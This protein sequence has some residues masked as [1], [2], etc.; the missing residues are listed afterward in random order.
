MNA[1]HHGAFVD[2]QASYVSG[3]DSGRT[4]AWITKELLDKEIVRIY[5][6]EKRKVL[7]AAAPS[8]EFRLGESVRGRD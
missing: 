1:F 6:L 3:K 2:S 7:Q 4:G 5:S 8:T